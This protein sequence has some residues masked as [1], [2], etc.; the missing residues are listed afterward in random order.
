MIGSLVHRNKASLGQQIWLARKTKESILE[1]PCS[2]LKRGKL[3]IP[4][5]LRKLGYPVNRTKTRLVKALASD[6][7]SVKSGWGREREREALALPRSLP[8]CQYLN[9]TISSERIQGH[10]WSQTGVYPCQCSII[11]EKQHKSLSHKT[12]T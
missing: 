10:P 3:L 9:A 7:R 5:L 6:R 1:I 2:K 8:P 4:K 11:Y 12:L